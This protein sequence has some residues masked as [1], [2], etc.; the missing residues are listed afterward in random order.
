MSN[1]EAVQKKI[2]S[3][4]NLDYLLSFWRFKKFKLVFTNGC[5]D[6]LHQGHIEYLSK[7]CELGDILIIGLNTDNSVKRLKGNN[8]PIQDENSRAIILASLSFVNAVILFNEDTPYKLIEKIQPDV[9]VKGGDYSP[10][11]IVGYDIVKAK[12]GEV[13]TIEFVDGFSSSLL[14]NKIKKQ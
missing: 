7:A 14:I 11:E 10:A 9:L 12:G 8:R 1:L 5:F 2:I 4:G 3:P 6:V 13:K